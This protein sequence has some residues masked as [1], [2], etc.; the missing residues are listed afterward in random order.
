VRA[1]RERDPLRASIK[2]ADAEDNAAFLNHVEKCRAIALVL[3]QDCYER[4]S[5]SRGC[6]A[7]EA[8]RAWKALRPLMHF[9]ASEGVLHMDCPRS[10]CKRARRCACD[11]MR[12]VRHEVL[13]GAEEAEARADYR[14]FL[15][16]MRAPETEEEKL[17]AA[18]ERRAH[19]PRPVLTGRGCRTGEAGEAGE[20]QR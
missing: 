2:R 16:L 3:W 14:A 11:S 9:F 12:C 17:L 6:A 15:A 8:Y 18:K 19:F 10:V 7:M 5:A 20:G 4:L 13:T 1:R